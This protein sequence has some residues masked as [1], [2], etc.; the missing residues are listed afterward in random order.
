MVAKERS[1]AVVWVVI[2]EVAVLEI[3]LGDGGCADVAELLGKRREMV[4]S[5]TP[6]NLDPKIIK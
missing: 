6:N 4:G 5:N 2:V 3:V 1:C